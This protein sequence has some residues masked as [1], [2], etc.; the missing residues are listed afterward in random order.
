[1]SIVKKE[2]IIAVWDEEKGTI[3][4]DCKEKCAKHDDSDEE[5]LTIHDVDDDEALICNDC[6]KIIYE[7]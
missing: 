7:G 4:L 6:R 5:T 2:D 3:C 1:M